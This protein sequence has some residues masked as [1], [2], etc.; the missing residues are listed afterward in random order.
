MLLGL[1]VSSCSDLL[2]KTPLDQI[3][4]PQFW[5][6]D[7]DLQLYVNKLYDAFNAQAWSTVGSGGGPVPDQGTDV[8]ISQGN[9]IGTKN[10]MD[11]VITVPT[12]GGG[13]S[14]TNV[15]NVD[16]FLENCNRVTSGTLKDQYIGEAY[17]F[18]AWFYFDLL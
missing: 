2:D 16:Y 1:Q 15:R 12:T 8:V 3:S 10:R 13:W 6:T 4:D 17:F 18:R 7:G 9:A 11:G 5:K 14:W